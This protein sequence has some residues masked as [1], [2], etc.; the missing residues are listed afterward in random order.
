VVHKQRM[1]LLIDECWLQNSWSAAINPKGAF[2]CEIAAA[3][4]IL[5]GTD[6]AW[7][8]EKE[9]WCRIPKDFKEQMEEYCPQ[10]GCAMPLLRRPSIDGRDD[11]SPK[12]LEKLKGKSKKIDQG[13]Y[14]ISDLKP[15]SKLQV[16]ASYKDPEYRNHIAARYGIYLMV[17]EKGFLVP[18]LRKNYDFN[19]EKRPRLFEV[20]RNENC[21]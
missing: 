8:V 16:M 4:S 13:R 14:V 18:L 11:I 2:F 17:N 1:F 19:I 15:Q 6:K 20:W 21:G 10:C 5:F 9:W 3:M 12:M 7:K